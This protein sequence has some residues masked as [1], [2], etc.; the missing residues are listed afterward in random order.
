MFE[1]ISNNFS[2]CGI[3]L[4]LFREPFNN[5]GKEAKPRVTKGVTVKPENNEKS[6]TFQFSFSFAVFTVILSMIF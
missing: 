6:S 4:K 1:I 3:W 5:I 2:I